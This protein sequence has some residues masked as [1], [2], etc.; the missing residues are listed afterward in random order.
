MHAAASTR[1]IYTVYTY[2]FIHA[3]RNAACFH[4]QTKSVYSK[5]HLQPASTSLHLN[6]FHLPEGLNSG[7]AG[8]HLIRKTL[9]GAPGIPTIL[10]KRRQKPQNQN[11]KELTSDST[12]RR[13]GIRGLRRG[14]HHWSE[15]ELHPRN[16]SLANNDRL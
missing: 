13:H 14:Q 15:Q 3:D 2:V 16:G 5:C 12:V 4:R 11:R 1:H 9:S 8:C 10:K 7:T 6:I